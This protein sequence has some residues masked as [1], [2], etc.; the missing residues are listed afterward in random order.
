MSVYQD[1][2]DAGKKLAEELK[3]YDFESLCI[4]AVPRGG[5]AVAVPIAQR[6][7]TGL[8]V[9]VTRKIG[10]P[11]SPEFAVGAVMPDG[12]AVLDGDTLRLYHVPQDYLEKAIAKEYAELRRRM[13]LYTGN[14]TLPDVG[15]KTVMVVDDGIATGYTMKAAARWLKTRN[16]IKIILAAPVAPP[17]TVRELA[18]EVDLVVCP[19]QPEPF[20]SVGSFYDDFSQITDQEVMVILEEVNRGTM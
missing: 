6:Y 12:S 2:L 9:L 7:N 8:Q 17:D 15:G 4:L 1:R 18:K 16:P 10:H 20:M 5:I 19:L 13:V 11:E 14:E 3:S